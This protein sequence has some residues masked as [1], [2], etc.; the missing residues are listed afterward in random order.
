MHLYFIKDYVPALPLTF[1]TV[2]LELKG[3]IKICF[4]MTAYVHDSPRML[5]GGQ[6]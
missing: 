5:I 3:F 2:Y 4:S 6:S 1:P